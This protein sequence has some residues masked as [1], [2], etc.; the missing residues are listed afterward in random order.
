MLM[1]A[2]KIH[3]STNFIPIGYAKMSQSKGHAREKYW[4]ACGVFLII[5]WFIGVARNFS[6]GTVLNLI[7]FSF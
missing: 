2:F 4:T 7:C 1:V 6:G 5:S 3:G